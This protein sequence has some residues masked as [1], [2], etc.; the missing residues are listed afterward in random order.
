MKG[1]VGVRIGTILCAYCKFSCMI[2]NK[3]CSEL[4]IT[5]AHKLIIR[6]YN[7]QLTRKLMKKIS[8]I[9]EARNMVYDAKMLFV[10]FIIY[11]G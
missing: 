6:T 3:F 7:F 1:N 10:V 8:K 9:N 4:I 11:V 5:V 2:F